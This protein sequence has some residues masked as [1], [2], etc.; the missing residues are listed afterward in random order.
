VVLAGRDL[1]RLNSG[2]AALRAEIPEA[3]ERIFTQICDVTSED[4]VLA[5]CDRAATLGRFTMLVVN[6]GF[7]SA[8]PQSS[9]ISGACIPVDGGHHLR[10]GPDLSPVMPAFGSPLVR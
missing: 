2:Q 7:G 4:A 3:A 10:R 1:E 6:A 5:T 9:W 8:G